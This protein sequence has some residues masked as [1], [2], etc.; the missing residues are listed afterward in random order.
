MP[1]PGARRR[2]AERRRTAPQRYRS[3][4]RLRHQAPDGLGRPCD[5]RIR[6]RATARSSKTGRSRTLTSSRR[7]AG[8]SG[9]SRRTGTCRGGGRQQLR[10]RSRERARGR[11][12]GPGELTMDRSA[13]MKMT[14]AGACGRIRGDDV[15]IADGQKAAISHHGSL[16]CGRPGPSASPVRPMRCDVGAPTGG[17]ALPGSG[18]PVRCARRLQAGTLRFANPCCANAPCCPDEA[19]GR[20]PYV[21]PNSVVARGMGT[22]QGRH[23]NEAAPAGVEITAPVRVPRRHRQGH[24]DRG[25]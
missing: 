24:Q 21:Q 20:I 10:P 6:T 16:H 15:A 14:L 3:R 23:V 13:L 5:L 18:R 17:D 4:Y 25:R 1:S 19:S 9:A 11:R 7:T 2:P 12:A 8:L 22:C